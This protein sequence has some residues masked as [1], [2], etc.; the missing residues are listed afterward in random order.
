MW[1]GRLRIINT[2]LL[3]GIASL[4]SRG[5]NIGG[6]LA[7]L[8]VNGCERHATAILWKKIAS[9]EGNSIFCWESIVPKI[10]QTLSIL[11]FF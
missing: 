3:A 2:S 9:A 10:C 11:G 4:V 7:F 1:S 5:R 8:T 6:V